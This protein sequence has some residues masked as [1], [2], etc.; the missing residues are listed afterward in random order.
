MCMKTNK[1]YAT[2]ESFAKI[3]YNIIDDNNTLKLAYS[4]FFLPIVTFLTFQFSLALPS[5]LWS[6]ASLYYIPAAW[7]YDEIDTFFDNSVWTWST[8]YII[9][10][11]M[12][13]GV[14]YIVRCKESI[15]NSEL[16]LLM[17]GLLSLYFASV[18]SGGLCHQHFKSIDSMN[19]MSFRILWFICV[20][21]VSSAGGFIGAIGSNIARSLDILNVQSHFK[22]IVIPNVFWFG[23]SFIFTAI[24]ATGRMRFKRPP[25]DIFIAGTTQTLPS[26]YIILV[27]LSHK[28]KM[29]PKLNYEAD[30]QKVKKQTK[31]IQDETTIFHRFMIC[32]SFVMNA[33]LLPMY[34]LLLHKQFSLGFINTLLHTVLLLTWSLQCYSVRHFCSILAKVEESVYMNLS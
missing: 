18:V 15:L 31:F 34:P 19:S 17:V 33:P 11:F 4:L 7:H 14:M 27:I 10:I 5:I 24:C 29:L 16:R 13:L 22:V 20:G 9:A 21:T 28:W 1:A 6:K 26:V 2:D 8:D 3:H 25:C 32:F 30:K 12:A 23:W